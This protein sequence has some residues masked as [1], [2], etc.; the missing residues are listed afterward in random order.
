MRILTFENRMKRHPSVVAR[1][2]KHLVRQVLFLLLIFP[3]AQAQTYTVLHTFNRSG[4]GFAA[5]AGLLLDSSGNLYGTTAGG[6]S[7]GLGTVFALSADREETIL[8]SFW[9]GDG[10]QPRGPLIRNREG[11]A[12]GTTLEGGTLDGGGCT[13]GCGSVFELDKAGK[14]TV[15]YGFPGGADGDQPS[16]RLVRDDAGDIYGITW[17]GGGSNC[18]NETNPCGDVF[19]LDKDSK[20]TVLHTFTGAPDGDGPSGGLVR[21]KAGDFYGVT[22]AGGNS[23][24]CPHGCGI[25]FKLDAKGNETVLY[26]FT[27]E[28]GYAPN[29][30]LLRDTAG[31]FYGTTVFGGTSSCDCGVVFKLD[32]SGH[33]TVLYSFKGGPDGARPAGGLVRDAA[34]NLYGTTTLGGATGCTG[35]CGTVFKL[36][37]GGNETVLY[38]FA[39]STDGANPNGGIVMD[40]AGNLYGT[41]LDG[42]DLSCFLGC[43]V[44]FKLAP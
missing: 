14:E 41:T 7:F 39:G 11:I 3:L 16:G 44:V 4:D 37:S 23:T 34:G 12:Y 1:S 32:S 8:H 31:N 20:E 18:P 21:D 38:T 17:F 27:G 25:V 19:K 10:W 9:G 2:A 35:G 22:G 28:T 29:G 15:L 42:G 43:G 6:G 26:N 36:D 30:P 24:N 5:E 40:R 13:F 33:E